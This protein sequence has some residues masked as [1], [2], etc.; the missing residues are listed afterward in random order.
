MLCTHF[1]IS[2]L[3]ESVTLVPLDSL[4]DRKYASKLRD[5]VEV[6]AHVIGH[7]AG[8]QGDEGGPG[9]KLIFQRGNGYGAKRIAAPKYFFGK[10]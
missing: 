8:G 10:A 5:G 3:W 9:L 6:R 1:L 2:C 4:R 7:D